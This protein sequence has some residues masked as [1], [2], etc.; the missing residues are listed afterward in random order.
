MST[1]SL[2]V[3]VVTY[4]ENVTVVSFWVTNVQYRNVRTRPVGN[5]VDLSET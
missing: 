4:W 3:G 1:V 2:Y 5:T